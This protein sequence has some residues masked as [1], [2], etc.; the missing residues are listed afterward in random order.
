MTYTLLLNQPQK[1]HTPSKE[2]NPLDAYKIDDEAAWLPYF[3]KQFFFDKRENEYYQNLIEVIKIYFWNNYVVF[4]KV[5]IADIIKVQCYDRRD[6][7]HYTN[8]ILPKHV[9]FVICNKDYFNPI[10]AIELNWNSHIQKDDVQERD[11]QK[12][13]IFKAAGLPLCT[14]TNTKISEIKSMLTQYL[15]K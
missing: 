6:R 15:G 7:N 8:L 14:V 2:K 13:L 10:L 11:E 5:R 12:R 9:D 3:K 4:S 1:T